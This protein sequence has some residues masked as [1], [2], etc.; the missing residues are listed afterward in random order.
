MNLG[1]PALAF[2]VLPGQNHFIKNRAAARD[3]PFFIPSLFLGNPMGEPDAS[4]VW[5]PERYWDYLL[6]LARLRLN[7]WLRGKVSASELVQETMLR[8]EQHRDQFRGTNETA[9]A[10]YLRKIL[11]NTL[12]DKVREF[13]CDKRDIAI[14]RSIQDELDRSS[15]HL[16][17]W[18]KAE[19]S[20]PS[21]RAERN[22]LL[23]NLAEALAQLPEDERV[24]LEMHYL[25]EPPSSLADIATHLGRPTAK[26]VSN[27][28][29]R[30]LE[31]L[32][33]LLK[34]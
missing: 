19:Q 14:E 20:S 4:D 2:P 32:R 5:K 15:A 16:E 13:A 23:L 28:L 31:R 26:A 22:E 29:A 27:L 11:A 34:D 8:A 18:L 3:L 17:N 12:V 7:A 10:A 25:Q 30:G 1:A 21:E 33:K 6:M 9:L 24:A